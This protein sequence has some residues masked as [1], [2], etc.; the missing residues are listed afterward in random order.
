MDTEKLME[1][2]KD[3][4]RK[5]QCLP[6][7][8]MSGCIYVNWFNYNHMCRGCVNE[9]GVMVV[10]E[11]SSHDHDAMLEEYKVGLSN[12]AKDRVRAML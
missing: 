11:S 9:I 2:I 5:W 12:H 7:K 6:G 3:K 4:V 10:E 8:Q 1:T